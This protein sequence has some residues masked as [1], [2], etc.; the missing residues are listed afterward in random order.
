MAP[1]TQVKSS[2]MVV[3]IFS[4]FV[5][6]CSKSTTTTISCSDTRP[7]RQNE[8]P[9]ILR[10]DEAKKTAE[11]VVHVPADSIRIGV[12]PG[13]R[14]GRA[15]ISERTYEIIVPADSGGE[16]K[17]AWNR[18]QFSFEIDRFTGTG[19]LNIGEEKYGETALFPL[20]CEHGKGQR[21]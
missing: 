3:S 6:G 9:W 1:M 16:G 8:S 18:M 5:G 11:M 2:L 21:L 13:N 17:G 4:V 7:G 19:K 15:D 14:I 12:P 20:R 10:I